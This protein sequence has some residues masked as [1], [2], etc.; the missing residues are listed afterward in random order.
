VKDKGGS[1]G[2]EEDLWEEESN[3]SC[4]RQRG[5]VSLI[6]SQERRQ[7]SPKV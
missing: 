4:V 5:H 1:E 2:A 6:S 7:R 3:I